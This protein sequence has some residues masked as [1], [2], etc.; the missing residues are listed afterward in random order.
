MKENG[1]RRFL[2]SKRGLLMCSRPFL[3]KITVGNVLEVTDEI[4]L[5]L[6]ANFGDRE[7]L[8]FANRKSFVAN[9]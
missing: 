6:F 4:T 9:L 2:E 1:T 3:N 5:Y 8:I 7:T